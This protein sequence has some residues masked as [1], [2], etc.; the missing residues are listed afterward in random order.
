M[1]S[2]AV[3]KVRSR[4]SV[5]NTSDTGVQTAIT[6]TPLSKSPSSRAAKASAR[7]APRCGTSSQTTRA[8][9]ASMARM[10]STKVPASRSR[11]KHG[12]VQSTQNT[13][14]NP[15]TMSAYSHANAVR[16]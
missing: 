10:P 7:S 2:A 11:R 16:P 1:R 6:S 15:N 8:S 3:S 5:A 4:C 14:L 9:S 12:L 13:C